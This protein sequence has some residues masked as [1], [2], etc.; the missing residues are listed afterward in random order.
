MDGPWIHDVRWNTD[1]HGP[2]ARKLVSESHGMI[3]DFIFLLYPNQASSVN[4]TSEQKPLL[5]MLNST[6]MTF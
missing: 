2:V 1:L 6:L 4:H 5:N 3:N